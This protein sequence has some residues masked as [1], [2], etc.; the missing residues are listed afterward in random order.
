MTNWNV[1]FI[2][3]GLILLSIFCAIMSSVWTVCKIGNFFCNFLQDDHWK[4]HWYLG[5]SSKPGILSKFLSFV[6]F[7]ILYNNL[8]PISLYVTVEL[9]KF[10]QAFL[11]SNDVKMYHKDTDTPA[12][13]RTSNLNEELGITSIRL[14][15]LM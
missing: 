14:F 3:I 15:Y 5:Y 9:V 8:I 6:T 4:D 12:L 1:I 11:I 10:G 7:V 13:A 2:F